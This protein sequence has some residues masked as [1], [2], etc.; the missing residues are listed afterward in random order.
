MR[1]VKNPRE[2]NYW[3]MLSYS[4]CPTFSFLSLTFLIVLADIIVFTY[5]ACIGLD[6]TSNNLLQIKTQT[7]IDHGGNYQ[8][9]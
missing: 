4:L 6:S 3:D 1:S 5:L 8:A 7:L 2:E 9:Y